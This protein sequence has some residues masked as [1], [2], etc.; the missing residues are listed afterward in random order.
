MFREIEEADWPAILEVANASFEFLP[1]RI[2]QEEW[3]HHRRNFDT[4]RGLQIHRVKVDD[5]GRI[6][7]YVGVESDGQRY[8]M[9]MVT[10]NP[11][12]PTLGTLLYER[13]MAILEE[14][15]APGV[16]L[17]EC[18]DDPLIAFGRERGFVEVRRFEWKPG[19]EIIT[20]YKSLP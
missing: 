2:T 4:E 18:I 3:L 1:Q 17:T 5:A 9:F 16:A 10:A 11:D 15:G 12:L 19:I 13:A 7:G 20:M 8:R 14:Q 6:V